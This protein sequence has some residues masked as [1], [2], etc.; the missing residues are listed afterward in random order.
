MY[1]IV[2]GCMD[3]TA[4][5]YDSAVNTIDG[6]CVYAERYFDCDDNCLNDSDG[7]GVCDGYR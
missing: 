5:N 2:F 7:D 3:V 6:S 4:C 1:P